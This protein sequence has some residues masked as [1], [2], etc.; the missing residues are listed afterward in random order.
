MNGYTKLFGTIVTSSVWGYDSDTRIVWVTLM[1]IADRDGIVGASVPGLANVAGVSR[2][3]C[4][5][6]LAVFMSPDLDSRTKEHDGRRIEPIDGGWR[7]LNHGKY[8]ELLNKEDQREKTA[9]R[10]REWKERHAKPASVTPPVTPGNAEA[11]PLTP[12]NAG[13]DKQKQISE[14]EAEA[15]GR[16]GAPPRGTPS[17][18]LPEDMR[19]S[20]SAVV[21]PSGES[22]DVGLEWLKY[23]ADRET[24][25]LP[26]SEPDW[27]GWVLRAIG[28]AR[29]ERRRQSD[30]DKASE[31]RRAEDVGASA[32]A[33]KDLT[34][35]RP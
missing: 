15:K 9:R 1:A 18:A 13:N 19:S 5:R 22:V 27:R 24:K 14:A 29:K 2:E 35:F 30:R 28:F 33:R 7:L 8:R 34:G 25:L 6:A 20:A 17:I 12:S 11:L 16:E 3:A 4:E 31:G 26:T 21:D 23:L 10:Q 32:R